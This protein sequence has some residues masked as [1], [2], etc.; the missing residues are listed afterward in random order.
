MKEYNKTFRF[1]IEIIRFDIEIIRFPKYS[2]IW[3]DSEGVV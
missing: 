3:H 1:D 2:M